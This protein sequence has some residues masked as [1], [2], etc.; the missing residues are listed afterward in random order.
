MR[1]A[2]FSNRRESDQSAEIGRRAPIGVHVLAQFEFCERAGL[3]SSEL[4]TEDTGEESEALP[5]LDYL[6]DYEESRIRERLASTMKAFWLATFLLATGIVVVACFGSWRIE[7]GVLCAVPLGCVLYWWF[8]MVRSIVILRS[9]L[10]AATRAVPREPD[11][12]DLREQTFNWWELRRAGFQVDKMPEPLL[13]PGNQLIG[14]P[15]RVLRK[16]MLRIPVFRKHRGQCVVRDQQRV[17]VAAYCHLVE[18]CEGSQA[19]FG[20]VMFAG[21]YDVFLVPNSEENQSLLA[22]TLRKARAVLANAAAER[23]VEIP[24]Q[25]ACAT[26]P[27]GRPQPFVDLDTDPPSPSVPKPFRTAIG[28]GGGQYHSLCGDRFDWIPP[29]NQAGRLRLS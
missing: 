6:P 10:D 17:R 25:L 18:S 23:G 1:C 4:S 11:L 27:L 7:L 12:S 24:S 29:H 9:R 15:W 16:G 20:F 22:N 28:V 2:V 26:C 14:R 3:I 13:D 21:S 5:R 19:P 8:C